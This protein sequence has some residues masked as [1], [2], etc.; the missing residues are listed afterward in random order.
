MQALLSNRRSQSK[1]VLYSLQSILEAI[2]EEGQWQILH[3]LKTMDPPMYQYARYWDW[4][5]P[6]VQSE[7]KSNTDRQHI[8]TYRSEL[9][10]SINVLSL[11]EQIE[12][13]E[14]ERAGLEPKQEGENVTV[15]EYP[16]NDGGPK[17]YLMWDIQASERGEAQT[18]QQNKLSVAVHQVTC[19]VSQSFPTGENNLALLDVFNTYQNMQGV[20]MRP[21]FAQA[22]HGIKSFQNA[23][24][25]TRRRQG[26]YTNHNYARGHRAYQQKR[27][28]QAAGPASGKR[29]SRATYDKTDKRNQ[30]ND[31]AAAD[32]DDAD[33]EEGSSED[34]NQPG[35]ATV[36][37]VAAVAAAGGARSGQ[38]NV[39][40]ADNT[41]QKASNAVQ[42][43]SGESDHMNLASS[44][45][46]RTLVSEDADD[47]GYLGDD[48]GGGYYPGQGQ[49]QGGG[50]RQRDG[51]PADLDPQN[52]GAADM[53]KL[54]GDKPSS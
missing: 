48:V 30:A 28:A 3:Y 36:G 18:D 17:P 2:L 11:I 23:S 15:I 49:G 26:P 37:A 51:A 45:N 25:Q 31:D 52:F 39:R 50:E 27:S 44:T 41:D 20:G 14:R 38:K 5:K 19:T 22:T 8:P 42:M 9:E 16:E 34:D 29:K 6:W 10:L 12:R 32:N 46:K 47:A 1:A 33:S 53:D 24:H 43:E 13:T 35:Q 40:F 7:V 4:I 54:D 21:G